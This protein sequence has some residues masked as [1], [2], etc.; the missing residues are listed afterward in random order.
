MMLKMLCFIFLFVTYR[1]DIVNAF[2]FDL[3]S[4]IF[5]V[6]SSEIMVFEYEDNSLHRLKYNDMNGGV[7]QILTNDGEMIN[8]SMY[9]PS[10]SNDGK[11]IVFTSRASNITDDKL[12]TCH[13]IINKIDRICNNVYLYNVENKKSVLIKDKDKLLNGDSYV[14]IISGDGKSVIFETIAT[15]LVDNK[16]DCTFINGVS[17]C[18]NIYKYDILTNKMFLIST[19]SNFHGTNGNAV[20]PSISDD[21]RYITFQTN[22]DNLIDEP[23]KSKECYN[24]ATN[25][26]ETCVNVFL[27]DSFKNKLDVISKHNELFF[28]DTSGNALITNDGKYVI[29]ES[30]ATN[31]FDNDGVNHI[32]AYDVNRKD[33]KLISSQGDILNNRD[34]FLLDVSDD[35]GYVA[36][37]TRSTNLDGY[38][39]VFVYSLNSDK[40]SRVEEINDV[41]LCDFWKENILF[42][43]DDKNVQ[44][45]G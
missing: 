7:H 1:F 5:N 16:Y 4:E 21:G 43:Y 17:N 31:V 30:Y 35:S 3:N 28:N 22:A 18:I 45:S 15:N 40:T 6:S 41:T 9:F 10:V 11:F 12:K 32:Y 34:N 27:F 38:G 2:N 24:Y 8:D 19:K 23:E 26:E 25:K 29:F 44:Q 37:K 14:A 39:G 13:D 36:Y 20:F 42:V 33:V